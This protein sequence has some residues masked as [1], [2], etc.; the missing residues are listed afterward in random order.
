MVLDERLRL[1]FVF[2]WVFLWRTIGQANGAFGITEGIIREGRF[3]FQ[4]RGGRIRKKIG[5]DFFA[6]R[7]L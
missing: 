6:H 3:D 5:L 4:M 1:F 2:L 7:Q